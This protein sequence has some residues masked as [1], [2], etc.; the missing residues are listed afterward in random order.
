LGCPVLKIASVTFLLALGGPS[1]ALDRPSPPRPTWHK[2]GANIEDF[3]RARA[4][5]FA[6]ASAYAE[7]TDTRWTMIFIGCMRA[8]GWTYR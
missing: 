5:C 4:G 2:A 8:S 6:S 1:L 7:M 3:Q